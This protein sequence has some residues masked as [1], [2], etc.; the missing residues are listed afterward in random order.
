ML[1]ASWRP[2]QCSMLTVGAG[3]A[4]LPGSTRP[5]K[6]ARQSAA[7]GPLPP[8]RMPLSTCLVLP[9]ASSVCRAKTTLP[10]RVP[11]PAARR[12]L[13]LAARCLER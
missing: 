7:G 8:P 5:D 3:S 9:T 6:F 2:P 12:R 1:Q 11:V 4:S 10:W 13:P